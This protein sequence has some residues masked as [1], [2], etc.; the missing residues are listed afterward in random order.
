MLTTTA[1][2]FYGWRVAG[3]AFVLAAFGWGVG[4]YGPPV[5][6][7]AVHD[8]RGWSVVLVSTAVTVHFLVGAIAGANLPAIHRRLGIPT[9]TKVGALCLATGVLGWSLAAAPWQLLGAAL[10]SGTGWG[11]TSSVALN[12]I[13]APWFVR[14]RPAALGLA[15]NGGSLGGVIFSPLWVAAIGA[16]GFTTAAAVIGLVMVLT[17]WVLADVYFSRTPQQMGLAPDDGASDMPVSGAGAAPVAM[18]LPGA[19]LWRD[20]RF[21]TLSAG[22]AMGLFAQVGL[23]AHL[24][25]LLV[26][27]LGA[28]PAGLAMALVTIIAVAGRTLVGWLMPWG[29]DRRLVACACY[30][31]QLAGSILLLAAAGTSVPLLLLG[32]V[33]FGAGFGNAVSLPPLIAQME[34]AKDDVQRVVGLTVG[35]AQ[36]TFAFAP[37]LFGL[38]REFAPLGSAAGAAAYVFAAAALA[39]TLAIGAFLAGRSP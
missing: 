8:G 32:V 21:V 7:S 19:L 17:L 3:A 15:Y 39:Q 22:M 1:R 35:V 5:F 29:A 12:A 30:A 24:F 6:L 37:A 16:L 27:T 33:L 9:T 20:R 11:A 18:P 38:L 31:T 4:F 10:L 23:I 26:P 25:S 28:Q 2:A 36:G 34:F 13:V 14:S